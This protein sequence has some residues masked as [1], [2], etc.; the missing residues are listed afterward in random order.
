M[1]GLIALL[2][3]MGM[4]ATAFVLV[5]GMVIMARGNDVSGVRQNKMM[6]YRVLFQAVT[7]ALVVLLLA[8][9]GGR[10]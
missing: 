2:V 10:S 6:W 7:I 9:M 3:V 5:R 4:L 1:N 8:V